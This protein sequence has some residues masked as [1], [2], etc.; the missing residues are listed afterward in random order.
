[1]KPNLFRSISDSLAETFPLLPRIRRSFIGLLMF[2]ILF[3]S[4][5]LSESDGINIPVKSVLDGP[6][7]NRT[8]T[9]YP[10]GVVKLG[11]QF[12]ITNPVLMDRIFLP[13]VTTD[14]DMLAL[15]F[16]AIVSI[17]FIWITPKLQTQ[18]LF[19]KDISNAIRLLGY[20]LMLHGIMNIYRVIQY[21]PVRIETLTNHQFTS[22]R[23]FPIIQWAEL[24]FAL[25]VIAL[26]GLYKRGMKLQQEQDLTV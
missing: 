9:T 18:H 17:I 13:A 23:S 10:S 16:L 5:G 19:R 24:Y 25:V 26:A 1:M 11:G 12:K 20:L 4:I 22:M 6:Y 3:F 15:L 14:L 8:V 21:A 2:C 7:H